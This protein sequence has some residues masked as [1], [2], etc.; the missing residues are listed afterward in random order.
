MAATFAPDFPRAIPYGRAEPS[1]TVDS[2]SEM[3]LRPLAEVPG[4][5]GAVQVWPQR[6]FAVAEKLEAMGIA[7]FCPTVE[8]TQFRR[9]KDGSGKQDKIKLRSPVYPTYLFAAWNNDQD[10]QDILDTSFVY[11]V[12]KWSHQERLRRDL[13]SL[14]IVLATEPDA[15]VTDWHKAGVRVRVTAGS[16]QG[17]EGRIYRRGNRTMI[18]VGVHFMGQ[19][20]PLEIDRDLLERIE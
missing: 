17:C 16:F 12:L 9:R 15:Y 10:F 7:S 20:V 19:C 11:E 3:G 1:K 2:E 13:A 8:R 6:E 18:F 4:E 5:W 14:E